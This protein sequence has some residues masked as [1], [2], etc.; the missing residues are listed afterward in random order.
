MSYIHLYLATVFGEILR[1]CKWLVDA[2]HNE[3]DHACAFDW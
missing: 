3:K 1:L 2:E